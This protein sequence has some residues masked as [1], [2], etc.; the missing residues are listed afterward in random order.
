MGARVAS[1]LLMRGLDSASA[2]GVEGGRGR[3]GM[4]GLVT[5]DVKEYENVA[6]RMRSGK[7]SQ[8]RGRR[9]KRRGRPRPRPRLFRGFKRVMQRARLR[10]PLFRMKEF[11]QDFESQLRAAVEIGGAGSG[12]S[13]RTAHVY[14]P[15]NHRHRRL[16][17]VPMEIPLEMPHDPYLAAFY[18][19]QEKETD[20]DQADGADAD[21]N[22]NDNIF[23]K[24][25]SYY[26]PDPAHGLI[27]L[28]LHG[29]YFDRGGDE[30]VERGLSEK[31]PSGW[32]SSPVKAFR[33]G[34]ARNDSVTAIYAMLGRGGWP[35]LG[36]ARQLH[37][38][39]RPG[40][41]LFVYLEEG[42]GTHGREQQEEENS[43]ERTERHLAA[44]GFCEIKSRVAPFG[45]FDM[46]KEAAGEGIWRYAA[47]V[48][49]KPGRP[50]VVRI[51]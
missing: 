51:Q 46:R 41:A 20:A 35:G 15:P 36:F 22:N 26:A 43:S 7:V 45:S 42:E 6:E 8:R 23:R 33:L 39:L 2:E 38:A 28:H 10:E 12:A 1:S 3:T 44:A 30:A 32:Q 25:A 11:A 48:C 31:A 40:G 29:E 37:G 9:Q 50:V 4:G 18:Q 27:L 14:L 17:D 21:T 24:S 19:K 5:M 47:K 49:G 16:T 34:R 13:L